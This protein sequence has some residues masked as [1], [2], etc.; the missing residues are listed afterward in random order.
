MQQDGAENE[1]EADGKDNEVYFEHLSFTSSQAV[2][3]RAALQAPLPRQGREESRGPD[4]K[5]RAAAFVEMS[6]SGFF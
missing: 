4:F 2:R 6:M 5:T 1:R 3:P